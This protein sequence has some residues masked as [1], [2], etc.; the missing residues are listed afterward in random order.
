MQA[1]R[2]KDS[3][4]VL[5]LPCQSTNN[6]KR[7][8]ASRCRL[9]GRQD[10]P[11]GSTP[12]LVPHP[13]RRAFPITFGPRLCAVGGPARTLTFDQCDFAAQRCEC[14]ISAPRSSDQPPSIGVGNKHTSRPGRLH[15]PTPALSRHSTGQLSQRTRQR[16]DATPRLLGVRLI[17]N[18]HHAAAWHGL[19]RGE[20]A[21][22][23]PGSSGSA[24]SAGSTSPVTSHDRSR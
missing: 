4:V 16:R 13:R 10:R 1:D 20:P 9:R 19:K 3:R 12:R 8:T 2:L 24:T 11:V 17:A 21:T 7:N 5:P 6:A 15:R 14:R 18:M 23:P 22:A